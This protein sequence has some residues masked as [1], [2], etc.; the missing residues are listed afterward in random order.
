MGSS[1]AYAE[2]IILFSII[3]FAFIGIMLSLI[4]TTSY[5]CASADTFSYTNDSFTSSSSCKSINDN[6][7]TQ[8]IKV[9]SASFSNLTTNITSLGVWNFIV[10]APAIIGLI[11]V[12]M[13]LLTPGWI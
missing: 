1:S 8:D 7:R 4:D 2:P 11:Y 5:K 10:F 3:Y 12:F 6:Y 9:G 13:A